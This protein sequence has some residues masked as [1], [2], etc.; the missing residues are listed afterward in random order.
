M[1]ISFYPSSSL[2]CWREVQEEEERTRYLQQ[3]IRMYRY[4]T[5]YMTKKS[6]FASS[7]KVNINRTS[8]QKGID[9]SP[10]FFYFSERPVLEM[11]KN[12]N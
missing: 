10:F 7:S 5:S 6:Q 2:L 4:C 1:L 8:R 11:T 3:K 9:L 12:V